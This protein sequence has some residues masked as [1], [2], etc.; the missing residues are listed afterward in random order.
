MAEQLFF[1]D[2]FYAKK[3]KGILKQYWQYYEKRTESESEALSETSYNYLIHG[4]DIF[5]QELKNPNLI[6]FDEIL[7]EQTKSF[8]VPVDTVRKRYKRGYKPKQ[9]RDS[10][11]K[12]AAKHETNKVAELTGNGWS[13][14]DN[15]KLD[16]IKDNLLS[17]YPFLDRKDLQETIDNYCKLIV[18]INNIMSADPITNNVAVKNLTDTM[19]RLG[20]YLGINEEAKQKQ[21]EIDDKKSIASLSLQF[22]QT[23]DAFPKLIDRLRYEEIRI[24]LEKYDSGSN[25]ISKELFESDSYAGMS[26]SKA[27]QFI[28]ERAK[29]YEAKD[30]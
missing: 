25:G 22:Q 5:G 27:R 3:F 15:D 2:D 18:K 16:R 19:I 8:Y 26:V 4:K 24:L 29:K 30:A 6:Y 21:K 10:V 17:E 9:H 7:E 14:N 1:I 12:K 11:K 23:L 20:S 28:K 13:E